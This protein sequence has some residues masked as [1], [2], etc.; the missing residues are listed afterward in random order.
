MGDVVAGDFE[1]EIDV[2]G[3]SRSYAVHVPPGLE[4]AA[5]IPVVLAFHGGRSNAAGMVRFCGMNP[6]ADAAGFIAVYPN[7]TGPAP[8]LLSWNAGICC[9]D[10][11][12]D[13]RPPDDVYFVLSMLEDLQ[14]RLPVDP[15]RI[16]A[17]G[18]SN[19]GMLSYRLAAEL[20]DRIAAIASVGGTMGTKTCRARQPVPVLHIHGTEDHFVPF[21]GGRGKRSPSRTEFVS[22]PDTIDCWRSV[23]RCAAEP[24][25]E[26]LPPVVDDGTSIRRELYTAGEGGADVDLYIVEGGGHTWPGQKPPL[27]FLGKSTKNL[28]ANAVIWDFFR[29]HSN[30]DRPDEG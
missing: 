1:F 2:D 17:T 3:L 26:Q 4:E 23:N 13:Q 22:V 5:S 9:N 8:H 7:G 28:D 12:E 11:P 15:G 18:M 10:G 27:L 19:G 25:R 6:Q 21:A 24:V 20:P 29:R 14:S 30:P 16:F